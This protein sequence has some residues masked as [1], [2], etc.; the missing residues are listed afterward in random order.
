MKT[1]IKVV[2][3]LLLL[4]GSGCSLQRIATNQTKS[5]VKITRKNEREAKK[6]K[7]KFEKRLIKTGWIK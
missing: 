4:G 6:A 2:I 5:F 3:V 7:R 1:L